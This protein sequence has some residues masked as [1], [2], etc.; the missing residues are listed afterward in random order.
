MIED[1]LT[2]SK[3]ERRVIL[4]F[5]FSVALISIV[6][7]PNSLKKPDWIR[8]DT[9]LKASIGY[10]SDSL[11]LSRKDPCVKR[12]I[13]SMGTEDWV[14]L[15][16]PEWL[17]VRIEKFRS[18]GGMISSREDLEKIYGIDT[19]WI[20]RI[21]SCIIWK[22]SKIGRTG[23]R[24]PTPEKELKIFVNSAD[25]SEWRALRGIGS[26]LSS[27]IIKFRDK[28]GGFHNIEQVG[29]TYG[30]N[31]TVF[32]S[33]KK[34][35]YLDGPVKQI[36]IN[37]SDMKILSAHPYISFKEARTI[38]SYRESHGPFR[39]SSTLFRMYAL[40]STRVER[41]LPYI[42]FKMKTKKDTIR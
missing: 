4:L 5:T 8:L 7:L 28:L 16:A 25:T 1:P 11:S 33:L 29:E 36:P 39:D 40:D 23:N 22:S 3:A 24:I 34:H 41:W 18:K 35:L 32:H 19:N 15:G 38:I 21:D 42:S 20:D 26:V 12:S 30:L 27:R 17:A 31:D 2:F 9:L 14:S 10:R 6:P 37:S 13:E